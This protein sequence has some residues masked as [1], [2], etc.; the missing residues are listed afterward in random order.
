MRVRIGLAHQNEM[1]MFVF[2]HPTKRLATEQIV[3]QDGHPSLGVEVTLLFHP[4]FGGLDL[5]ILFF[6][7]ILRNDELR[8]QR[9]HR[10]IPRLNDHRGQGTMKIVRLAIAQFAMAAILTLDVLG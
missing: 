3:A 10:F 8:F 6:M 5:T 7:P 1:E 2:Q 9:N 4:T